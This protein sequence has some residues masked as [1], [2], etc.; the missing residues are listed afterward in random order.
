VGTNITTIMEKTKM[1]T[2]ERFLAKLNELRQKKMHKKGFVDQT[3]SA[4]VGL[5]IIVAVFGLGAVL[6]SQFK[7]MPVVAADACATAAITSIQTTYYTIPSWVGILIVVFFM[8][9][10]IG[11]IL[12]LRGAKKQN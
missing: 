2:V 5:V 4:V 1:N 10:V 12:L 3:I 8:V 9:L 6:I 11:A 7:A